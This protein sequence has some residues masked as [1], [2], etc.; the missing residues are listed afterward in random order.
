MS[1]VTMNPAMQLSND[2]ELKYR[3]KQESFWQRMFM[4]C[5]GFVAVVVPLAIQIDMPRCTRVC[6]FGA[7]ASVSVCTLCIILL[8]YH[9]VRWRKK[10]FE[11]GRKVAKGEISALEFSSEDVSLLE[12][13]CMVLAILSMVVALGCL[14]AACLFA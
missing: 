6:L 1:N 10:L 4:G 13:G 12:S 5:T 9:S 3:D 14:G 2:L 7:V 8:L 11:K